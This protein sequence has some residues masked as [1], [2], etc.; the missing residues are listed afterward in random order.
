MRVPGG[1]FVVMGLASRSNGQEIPVTG[2]EYVNVGVFEK[3]VFW[4]V[5]W[6]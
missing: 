6:F 5:V 2:E 4:M 3:G 1:L